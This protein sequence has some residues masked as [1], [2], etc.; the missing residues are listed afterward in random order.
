MSME[1][2][3]TLYITGYKSF[4]I[5]VFQENDPKILVIKKV[6]KRE[7]T[8]YLNSG[9]EW[10]LVSGN[11]GTEMWAAEVVAELK[12]EYP[13]V[14]LAIIYPFQNFGE[15]WNEKNK[16]ALAKIEQLADYSNSVSHLPYQSPAQLK[17]HTRFLLEHSGAA[18]MVYD[19]EYPGKSTF[20]LKEAE[21]FSRQT[22]YEIRLITMDDLQNSVSE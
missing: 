14:K 11:L 16:A 12:K 15:N 4:E 7:L 19:K 3:K 18:L 5:G 17:M 13:E 2:I 9:T 6:L 20:F 1:K 22:P 8:D 21:L 10:V